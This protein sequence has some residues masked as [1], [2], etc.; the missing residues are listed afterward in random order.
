[1]EKD[2][3]MWNSTTSSGKY[4]VESNTDNKSGTGGKLM[5]VAGPSKFTL[6]DEKLKN[7]VRFKLDDEAIEDFENYYIP[8]KLVEKTPDGMYK[9]IA[10]KITYASNVYN[11]DTILKLD[12]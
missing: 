8:N 10:N 5:L 6:E 3:I 4:H 1:M 7:I 2:G 11:K 12:S 9:V